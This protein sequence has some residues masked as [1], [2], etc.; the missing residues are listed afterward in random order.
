MATLRKVQ[1]NK[2]QIQTDLGTIDITT[3]LSDQNLIHIQTELGTIIIRTNIQDPSRGLMESIQIKSL[4]HAEV[5]GD[6]M[7]LLVKK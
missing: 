7:V 4:P 1:R 3:S 2:I 5:E 6:T